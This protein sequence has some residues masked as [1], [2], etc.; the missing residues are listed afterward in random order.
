MGIERMTGYLC[1]IHHIRETVPFPRMMERL[2][3]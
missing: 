2:E 1:G 3:P